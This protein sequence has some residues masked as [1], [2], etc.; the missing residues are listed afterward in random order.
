M[1]RRVRKWT[2]TMEKWGC[3]EAGRQQHV[4]RYH[5]EEERDS[6]QEQV[7]FI[8]YSMKRISKQ[9]QHTDGTE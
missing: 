8:F 7:D 2:E 6:H 9:Q 3:R 1:Y 5:D 4:Y